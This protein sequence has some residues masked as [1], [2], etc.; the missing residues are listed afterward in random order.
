[1]KKY[2]IALF[3][4]TSLL[5]YAKT[6]NN[7]SIITEIS[8]FHEGILKGRV[9]APDGQ[10]LV[11][12]DVN[13]GNESTVTNEKG[14]YSFSNL[15]SGEYQ[16]IVTY[17]GIQ[18][19]SQ[20]IVKDG[21]T[22]IQ[23]IIYSS[24]DQLNLQEVI[25][26]AS[27]IFAEKKSDQVARMPLS[28]LENPQV[29]TVV[30]KELLQ[31]QVATDFR[32]A[33]LSSPGVTNVTLGVGSGG[34]GLAMMM[35]GFSGADGAGAIRNGMATNFVSLSD[36]VNLERLEIIKG[37]SSTLFGSTLVSYGGLVN[38]V[39]KQAFVGKK[40]EISLTGGGYNMGRFTVDYN[41]PLDD[42]NQT[43]FRINASVLNEKS[44]QDQGINKT[45]MIAPT[46]KYIVNDRF[47]LNFDMEY[48]H[49]N[50]NSTYVGISSG[51]KNLDELDWDFKKSYTS[52]DITSKADVVNIFAD[53]NYKINDNWTSDTRLSY[54]NT[55][56]DANYL[57]LIVKDGAG[58]YLGKKLL[59]RRLM[60]I[61]SNFNTIQ[62]QQNFT[63]VHEFGKI[64]NKFLAGIDFTQLRTSDSR[65]SVNDYDAFATT[66]LGLTTPQVTVMNGVA[67]VINRDI[68]DVAL[69][70]TTRAANAR[71]THTYS[72]Y[73]SNVLTFF[74]RLNV[75]A[76]L[77]VDRYNDRA[78]NYMQTAWSPK[79]G[80]VFQVIE[81]QL[82]VFGN[83]MNGFKNVAPSLLS[84]NVKQIFKPE[85][86]NQFEGGIKF[87]LLKGKINGTAS[88]YNIKVQD[89]VRSVINDKQETVSVQDGT[90]RSKGFEF[91]LIANPVNG[92]HLIV[93]Y[94]YN[95]SKFEKSAIDKNGN[96]VE[97]NTPAGVPHNS[98]NYWVSYKFNQSSLKGIGLGFG[99]NYSDGYFF[100]DANTIR[101]S[102]FHTMDATVFYEKTK[103]KLA[104]KM[105]NISDK[106]YWTTLSW[107]M[108][109]EGRTFLASLTFKF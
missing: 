69:S 85:Q 87:E 51:I 6:T 77:R 58:D 43:L 61:P 37:P 65:T 49:S 89:K 95:D 4:L 8:I 31:E 41:T 104:L 86:A 73:I 83:Y 103:Y 2:T 109:Q 63:A 22:T 30:P 5:S 3:T 94:G 67:P 25:V 60:N 92:L 64:K 29:Y 48:F 84:N 70:K 46:L 39:T 90:Q 42:S 52:N 107:A 19:T 13:L 80:L 72:A 32:G 56:N 15:S 78:N 54:S 27:K 82:S 105:N 18:E 79:L 99:G 75:M 50:R 53:A 36:P 96:T 97:G 28:N 100:N 23:N 20:V 11:G 38:R 81:N 12:A 66:Y 102:G 93:G 17:N 24:E 9:T 101:V 68:Y 47:T 16:L 7:V 88:Y 34:T 62:V 45:I 1:M 40:G 98:A 55:D 76:S 33:L 10:P 106:N 59:Q 74:D 26:D 14:E 44:F 35:R 91:D 108:P 71:D 21:E 57:F